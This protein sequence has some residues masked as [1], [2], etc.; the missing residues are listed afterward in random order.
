MHHSH[1]TIPLVERIERIISQGCT[2][3]CNIEAIA[4]NDTSAAAK[5][6]KKDLRHHTVF[7][8]HRHKVRLQMKPQTHTCRLRWCTMRSARFESV[9]V[10]IWG[11][12]LQDLT[13]DHIGCSGTSRPAQR[14]TCV[15]VE[16]IWT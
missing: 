5:C 15:N 8:L 13:L 2:L 9:S 4:G 6:F 10:D 7:Q 12:K 14:R 1:K 3:L 11:E 16:S